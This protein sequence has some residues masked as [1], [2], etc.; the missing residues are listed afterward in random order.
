MLFGGIQ[1]TTL[2]DYPGKIAC[3]LFTLG[4]DFRCSWCHNPELSSPALISSQPVIAPFEIL[5]FLESRK[6]LLQGVCITG[7]EPTI[8]PDLIDFSRR[9][10]EMGFALKIDS[11]GLHPEVLAKMISEGLVDYIAMDV[12]NR[13]EKY[14]MTVGSAADFMK[15]KKSIEIVRTLPDYEFRTTVVPGL[16]L[17][18]DILEIAEMIRG[19]KRYYLQPFQGKKVSGFEYDKKS[20][21]KKPE[22]EEIREKI[23]GYFEIC[24]VRG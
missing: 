16:V 22:L 12:K 21:L 7:G 10:K 2:V 15:I 4:C 1:K 3:V 20:V 8:Q 5:R 11:N 18:E 14:E 24:E 23:K 17:E 9:V 19:A 13:L 6:G